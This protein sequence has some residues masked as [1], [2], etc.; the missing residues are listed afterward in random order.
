LIASFAGN[1]K[2]TAEEISSKITSIGS[3]TLVTIGDSSLD[4]FYID[5]LNKGTQLQI[6]IFGNVTCIKKFK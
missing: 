3:E 1:N 4:D 6:A 5:I 2:I